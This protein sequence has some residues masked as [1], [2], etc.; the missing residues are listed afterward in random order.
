MDEAN[1]CRA[2]LYSAHWQEVSSSTI[3]SPASYDALSLRRQSFSRA[4][5]TLMTRQWHSSFLQ[6]NCVNLARHFV[7]FRGQLWQFGK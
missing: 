2:N 5:K 1:D 6:N 3:L 7:K 4:S